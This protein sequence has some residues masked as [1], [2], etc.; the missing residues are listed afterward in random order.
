MVDRLAQGLITRGLA[1]RPVMVLSQNSPEH[2]LL[3]LAAWTAGAPI[4]PVSVAYSLQSAD[5]LKLQAMVELVSPGVVFAQDA[6]YAAALAAVGAGRTVVSPAELDGALLLADLEEE[7]TG[8]VDARCAAVT[9]TDVAKILFTSGST[10]T[11]KGVLN[12]HGQM[13]ANQQQLRQAWPF[14]LDEPPVLLDW[15]PWSH[16]FGGNH[17]LG[18]VLRNAARSGST[19]ASRCRV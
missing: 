10:G 5:H 11:P 2:L 4:V 16:T 8:E 12:P 19:T 18:L 14:L 7:P 13:V 3:T 1:D 15:L 17:N 9:G 6:A